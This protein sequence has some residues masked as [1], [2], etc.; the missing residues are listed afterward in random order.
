MKFGAVLNILYT[1]TGFEPTT[2]YEGTHNPLAKLE[3]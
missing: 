2:T 3:W 1:A